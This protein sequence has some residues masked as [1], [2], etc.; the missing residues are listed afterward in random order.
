[1]LTLERIIACGLEKTEA[2]KIAETVNQL[3]VTQSPTAC[4]DEISR[5]VLTPQHPFRLHQLLY[6]TVYADFDTATPR[7]PTRMV[8]YGCRHYRGE[9][10]PTH[11]GIVHQNLS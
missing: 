9:Y 7:P 8:T 1:M 5:H 4:W 3:L 2:S 10:H 11:N 6:E